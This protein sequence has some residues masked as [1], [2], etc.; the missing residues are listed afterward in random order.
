MFI[1]LSE[2]SPRLKW[3][4]NQTTEEKYNCNS[5]FADR[6][7]GRRRFRDGYSSQRIGTHPIFH[8]R[9]DSTEA[10]NT[11]TFQDVHALSNG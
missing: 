9:L 5:H 8:V 3:D 2:T 11:F 7:S 6:T 1:G 4:L 10:S